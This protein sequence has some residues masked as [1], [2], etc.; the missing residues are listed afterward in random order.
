MAKLR[1]PF[2]WRKEVSLEEKINNIVE[3]R[4]N[5]VT[6]DPS[7]KKDPKGSSL[8]ITKVL[9]RLKSSVLSAIGGGNRNV[10]LPPEWDFKKVQLAFT[11]ESI[12][13]RSVEKY[14]EQ[15]RK[16]SWEFVGNNTKTVEY[17]RKRVRQMEIVSNKTFSDLI[18]E[19]S[20]NIVLYGNTT[21]VKKRNRKASGGNP[22]KTFDGYTRV[23][24]AGYEVVDPT[25]LLVDKDNFGNVR[26]WKQVLMSEAPSSVS[27]RFNSTQELQVLEW[28]AYNMI[29]MKDGSSTPS[30]YFFAMPMAIPVLADM[31][32]L[33]ELEEL[34]LLESIKIAVPKLHAKVGTKE[35]PGTQD[36][37]N[38]LAR[39][40]ETASGDGIIV[41][42]ERVDFDEIVKSNQANNI[43]TSSIGYFRERVLAGLGMSDVAM[44]KSGTSNRATAQ[45]MSSEMQSTSA[46]FQRV[47]KRNIEFHIIK[48]LLY[49]VGYSENTLTDDNMVYLSI[50]EVDLQ[51]KITREA[52]Y[53]NLY[54]SHAV[55]ED[56][57]RKEIGMD[58]IEDVARESMYLDRVQI[59]L[60]EAQADAAAK[61]SENASE[62]TSRPT[63]QHGKQLAKPKV[64]KDSYM[65]LWDTCAA[66]ESK[67]AVFSS[68]NQSFLDEYAITIVK[69]LLNKYL[70]DKDLSLTEAVHNVFNALERQITNE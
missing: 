64:N 49:E 24:V 10:F 25:T 16:H 34:Y 8:S 66:A 2:F 18:D 19:M 53:L 55:T 67:E 31:E 11:N 30:M 32:A 47:L 68:L 39:T 7:D 9:Q 17:I 26:K 59:K 23:P 56:E 42:T 41:T 4:N 60:A 44:G 69:V 13:R 70:A 36:Q 28:P 6:A 54:L 45:V 12:F 35:F 20:F 57:L 63:N 50:P 3:K 15:I 37:I 1:F 43:L 46:K 5:T 40:I 22:R 62:N 51:E 65:K 58:L 21:I 27:E 38:D 48:E 33:R 29:H 52:H 14:V 61:A